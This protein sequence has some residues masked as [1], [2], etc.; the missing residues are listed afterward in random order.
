MKKIIALLLATSLTLSFAYTPTQKDL[1]LAS[2][3][4]ALAQMVKTKQPDKFIQVATILAKVTKFP[5]TRNGWIMSELKKYFIL[6]LAPVVKNVVVVVDGDTVKI[7]WESIRM[8]WIDAPE[9]NT[10]RYGYTEC[11]GAEASQHLKDLLK[12][13]KEVTLEKDSTQWD[14]DK[15]GRTL[16]YVFADGVDINKKM[17]EDGYAFEYTYST[18]YK[19]QVEYKTES[20][21][22][23]VQ[24]K[25][26]WASS[27]CNGDRKKGTKDEVKPT[28]TSETTPVVTTT[29]PVVTTPPS[30]NN[31]SGKTYYTGPKGGC[32]YYNS[33]G[34]KSYVDR[35]LCN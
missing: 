34:N 32:Y 23:D 21:L 20:I 4:P 14:T 9:S 30:S 15:Y 10:S 25:W 19:Y 11:Y 1:K 29:P 31:S 8:I 3:L 33:N 35:S 5:N 7:N 2:S 27:T 22:A 16:W 12:D 26:M 13:A 17:I 24:D 28:T 6:D 18:K